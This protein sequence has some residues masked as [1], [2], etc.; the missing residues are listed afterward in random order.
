VSVRHVKVVCAHLVMV[1]WRMMFGEIIGKYGTAGLPVHT[2]I[3]LMDTVMHP[4][5]VH[6]D[7]FGAALF[8]CVV[9]DSVST[10][11]V[12]LDRCWRLWPVHPFEGDM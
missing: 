6:V 3:A 1:V 11:I 4:I 9:D 12:D 2:E 8:D 5:E 10:G 7:G